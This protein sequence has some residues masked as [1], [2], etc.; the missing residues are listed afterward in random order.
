MSVSP[1]ASFS[2]NVSSLDSRREESPSVVSMRTSFQRMH[3]LSRSEA[4][5]TVAQ[6]RAHLDAL[7]AAIRRYQ[8]AIIEA[9]DQDFGGRSRYETVIADIFPLILSL[10]HTRKHLARWAKPR[11]VPVHWAFQPG[12]AEVVP[13]P[14]GVVGIIAPWNYPVQLALSPLIS[15]LAA[16]NRAM[17]KPSELTPRAS[18]LI[19]QLI[20]E[21]FSPDTVT[22]VQGGVHIA[23]GF[24]KLPW[25]HLIF[26][27]ST[28]LGAIVMRA[29][30]ENL[31]PVTLELGGKSPAI[32][33][34]EHP[35]EHAVD[36]ILAGKMLNAGQTCIAPDYVLLGRGQAKEFVACAKDIVAKRY[37]TLLNNADYTALAN[38]G[39]YARLHGWLTEAEAKGATLLP[40]N[41]ANEDLP[42]ARRKMPLTLVLNATDDMTILQEEL[43]GPVLPLIEVDNVDAAI[44]YV[45]ERARP[46]ALYYFDRNKERVRHMLARTVSGDV[47]VNDTML[48]IVQEEL[49]FGGVG[50]AG[51]GAY[52]GK[53]GFDTFSHL[54]G[55]F[56]QSR[57]NA[58]GLMSPPYGKR[59]D[60]LLG[61]LMR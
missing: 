50:P 1:L 6:R 30:A 7:E 16:G 10:Q 25:D 2:A 38:D 37:P 21:T 23:E 4:P 49:P 60:Q 36:R 59:L 55:V 40:I 18:A 28:R 17:I 3:N 19:A 54:K 58:A 43:F 33:H 46:L 13:Q 27:G 14:L 35:M 34:P 8:P 12:A 24:G 15:A 31:T 53:R 56:W 9:I 39:Q 48:H 5:P 61:I 52:H 22:V 42:P 32:I 51:M 29:A 57:L 26:T 45:N 44:R 47:T 11:S 41:P 20:A